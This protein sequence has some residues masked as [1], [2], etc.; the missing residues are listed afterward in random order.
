MCKIPHQTKILK[1]NGNMLTVIIICV[2]LYL[3]VLTVCRTAVHI[4]KSVHSKSELSDAS[5][6]AMDKALNDVYDK[7]DKDTPANFDDIIEAIS[8]VWDDE[9]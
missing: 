2:T 7:P 8:E 1:G 9:E 3:S 6:A 4:V 5:I